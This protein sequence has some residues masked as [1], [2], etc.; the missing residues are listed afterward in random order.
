MYDSKVGVNS[1]EICLEDVGDVCFRGLNPTEEN[2]IYPRTLAV[3]HVI[4]LTCFS[5]TT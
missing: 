2:V 1:T 5:T 3:G 4:A